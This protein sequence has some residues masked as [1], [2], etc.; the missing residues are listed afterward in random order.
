LYTAEGNVQDFVV[1]QI[2][3][4][5]ESVE[6]SSMKNP[7]NACGTWKRVVEDE[8]YRDKLLEEFISK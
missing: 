3:E 5:L 2:Y 1:K 6:L 8:D 4:Y 7:S